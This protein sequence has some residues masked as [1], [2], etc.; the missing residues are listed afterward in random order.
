MRNREIKFR[1]ICKNTGKFVYGNYIEKIDPTKENPTFWASLI[2]N[3]A[4]TT[5]EVIDKTVGEYIGLKDKNGKEIYEGDVISV[6]GKYLKIIEFDASHFGFV[7]INI[8][9]LQNS[10]WMDVKQRPS[11]GWFS[12]FRREIEVI[13]NIH[14]NPELLNK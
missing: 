5:I 8:S 1:G 12:D 2:H 11:R 7:L 6:N 10:E 3:R 9:D 4:L 14:Q 13:G